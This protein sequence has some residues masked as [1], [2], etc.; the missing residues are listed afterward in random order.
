M[1]LGGNI[2]KAALLLGLNGSQ[3]FIFFFGC[4][5]DSMTKYFKICKKAGEICLQM[6]NLIECAQPC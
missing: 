4:R 6:E 5:F 1:S 3:R 2:L